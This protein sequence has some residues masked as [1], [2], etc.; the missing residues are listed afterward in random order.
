L[1]APPGSLENAEAFN[2]GAAIGKRQKLATVQ[3]GLNARKFEIVASE[4]VFEIE[5][6]NMAGRKDGMETV[7][8]MFWLDNKTD[9]ATQLA[10]IAPEPKDSDR[11]R[12]RDGCTL[13]RRGRE[14][15]P[16]A[17]PVYRNDVHALAST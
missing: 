12:G 4:I 15:R 10:L 2:G 3:S 8:W 6:A 11:K 14:G 7:E 16:P 5:V 13:R 9:A 17:A 1:A